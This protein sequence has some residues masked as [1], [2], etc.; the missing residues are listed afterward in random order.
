MIPIKFV[1]DICVPSIGA[2]YSKLS[3]H[4][5]GHPGL[6]CDSQYKWLQRTVLSWGRRNRRRPDASDSSLF[7]NLMVADLVQAIGMSN[8][9]MF[10]RNTNPFIFQEKC[11]VSNGYKGSVL[12]LQYQ[13]TPTESITGSHR[14][15]FMYGAG[16][17]KA[18]W[19]KW[20]GMDVRVGNVFLPSLSG[21][22]FFVDL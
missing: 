15:P 13:R 12:I 5:Q 21:L 22:H 10:L 18:G 4:S 14:G 11:Q 6:I 1:D 17:F 16:G 3:N 9:E 7:L 2:G 8:L 20:C 19:D